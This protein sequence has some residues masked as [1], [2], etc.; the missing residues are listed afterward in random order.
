MSSKVS[1]KELS[2]KELIKPLDEEFKKIG[3]IQNQ[4]IMTPLNS[5]F[6]KFK[7]KSAKNREY[8][9]DKINNRVRENN[10]RVK[11]L[12]KS[13]DSLMKTFKKKLKSLKKEFQSNKKAWAIL[14]TGNDEDNTQGNVKTAL[15]NENVKNA[16]TSVNKKL[17]DKSINEGANDP[18]Y[19]LFETIINEVVNSYKDTFEKISKLPEEIK[20]KTGGKDL[21][22]IA[23]TSLL[24]GKITEAKNNGKESKIDNYIARFN[25]FHKTI[26]DVKE[27]QDNLENESDKKMDD[28]LNYITDMN[29]EL[30][31]LTKAFAS[32]LDEA[33]KEEKQT[34]KETKK[35][36][37]KL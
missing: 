9:Y 8:D 31:T 34:K 37:S 27:N 30:K 15:E 13:S 2:S 36:V 35:R 16:I 14:K 28:A 33:K 7:I 24:F 32:A 25:S 6:K 3:K 22:K 17:S 23:N 5:N 19:E 4:L 1:L 20:D 10:K 11:D 12:I 26:R 21:K 18:R 29:K